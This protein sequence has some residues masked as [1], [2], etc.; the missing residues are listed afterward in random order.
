MTQGSAV[1][2]DTKA[3]S[4]TPGPWHASRETFGGTTFIRT[5]DDKTIAFLRGYKAPYKA[6]AQLLAAAPELL[7]A[8]WAMVTSF[9]AV[10]Y[11]QPHMKE[12]TDMARKAIAKALGKQQ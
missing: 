9:H 8:C 11:M 2:D 7:E 3:S 12:S 1:K 5:D 10:E 4:Y 6:N